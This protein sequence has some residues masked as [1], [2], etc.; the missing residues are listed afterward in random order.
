MPNSKTFKILFDMI[1]KTS[2]EI[3]V[4]PQ[5]NV[6]TFVLDNPIYHDITINDETSG[7][8]GFLFFAFFYFL[9]GQFQN[10]PEKIKTLPQNLF[11]TFGVFMM[12]TLH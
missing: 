8:L 1:K 2:S 11:N 10:S 4:N 9:C 5:T 12:N 3:S 7:L 6:A